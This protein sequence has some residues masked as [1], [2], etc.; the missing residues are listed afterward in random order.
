MQLIW[1]GPISHLVYDEVKCAL[2]F[3]VSSHWQWQKCNELSVDTCLVCLLRWDGFCL[4]TWLTVFPMSTLRYTVMNFALNMKGTLKIYHFSFKVSQSKIQH[5]NSD[6]SLKNAASLWSLSR[7]QNEMLHFKPMVY[8]LRCC[9]FQIT[10]FPLFIVIAEKLNS[11]SSI[12]THYVAMIFML[13][14]R[15]S[16]GV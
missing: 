12:M 4:D 11:E 14:F 16:L 7:R 5:S 15:K 10:H 8:R 6:D 3:H 2:E 1:S 9:V 13:S